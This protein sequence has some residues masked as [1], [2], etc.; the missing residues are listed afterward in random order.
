MSKITV[1]GTGYVGL[2]TGACLAKLG[3]EVVCADIDADK[4]QRLRSGD[5][6]IYEPGMQALVAQGL[7]SGRLSFVVDATNAVG[8]ADFVFLCVPTPQADDGSV[9]LKQLRDAAAE[10][11]E[12]VRHGAVIV[13]K[14]TVPV[15]ST[16]LVEEAMDR[17]DVDVVSNP[18]FLREGTA[19]DDFLNPDRLVIGADNAQAAERVVDL[20][21][22]IDAPVVITDPASAETAKYAANAFLA[23][24]LSFVNTIAAL[25]EAVDADVGDVL[26]AMGYDKRIGA[27]SLNPGPGW[28]G[29]CFPKDTQAII[30]IAKDAGYDFA[31]MRGVVKANDEQFERVV[32]KVA[33]VVSLASLAGVRV[34]MWGL[35]FKANTDDTRNSP[36]LEV[37]RR[38][39]AQGAE[40]RAYDPAVRAVDVDGIVVV[41]DPYAACQDVQVLLVVTEW[42]EFKSLDLNQVAELMVERN[43]VD[44]RNILDREALLARGFRYQGIGRN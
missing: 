20:Y 37:A 21:R 26:T 24:K 3:H 7:E 11:A 12:P 13:N 8:D 32:N 29:S 23:T 22:S 41:D 5:L 39:L 25:C 17:P 30:K 38:L 16:L 19:I 14:S 36:A 35:A 40:V 31:L 28:G 43:V 34:A 2:T 1:I 27:E 18:E 44:A 15:G 33:S 9:D 10:I 42:D 4:V 6:P